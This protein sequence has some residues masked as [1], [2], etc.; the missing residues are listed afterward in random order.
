MLVALAVPQEFGFATAMM[1]FML[2]FILQ[3]SLWAIQ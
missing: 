3:F 1:V 2:A